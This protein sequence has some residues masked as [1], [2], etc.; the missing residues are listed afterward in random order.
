MEQIYGEKRALEK[1]LEKVKA[2]LAK[3]AKKQR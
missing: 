3:V 1:E 2:E